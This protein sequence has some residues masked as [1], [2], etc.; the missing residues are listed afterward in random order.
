M[1]DKITTHEAD[2]L[3]RLLGQ[4]ATKSNFTD[5]IKAK[6]SAIQ[7][8]ENYFYDMM[9]VLD[10]DSAIGVWLDYIGRL[11]EQDRTAFSI[12]FGETAF[13]LDNSDLDSDDKLD[14]VTSELDDI[15]Y[16]AYIKVKIFKDF[17]KTKNIDNIYWLFGEVI[18]PHTIQIS[19]G[20][21]KITIDIDFDGDSAKYRI[22]QSLIADDAN[23]FGIPAGIEV[24]YNITKGFK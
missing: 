8:A 19:E 7:D 21:A 18:N 24:E 16:R 12:G 14:G 13:L 9:N 23:W 6:V 15:L 3:A 10:I 20:V 1:I 22:L 4:Y 5:F 2:A 11:V 17:K